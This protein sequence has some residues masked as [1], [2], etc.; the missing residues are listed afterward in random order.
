[1]TNGELRW[2]AGWLE[3]EGTFVVTYG[4]TRGVRYRRV[5]VNGTSTDH[6]VLVYVKSLAGGRIYGPY[7]NPGP[8]KET[9][10]VYQWTLS[11][12][13]QCEELLHRLLPYMVSSRRQEQVRAAI[14][15]I[16]VIKEKGTVIS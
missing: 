1:M 10:P 15:G 9:K 12:H 16:K 14:A 3:G 11:T 6:D 8:W 13:T 4:T 7:K 5:R 2:L